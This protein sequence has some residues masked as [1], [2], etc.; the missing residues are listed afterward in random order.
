[1]FCFVFFSGF[2][3]CSFPFPIPRSSP[4]PTTFQE[5]VEDTPAL[6]FQYQD[7]EA[8]TCSRSLV[9]TTAYLQS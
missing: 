6:F 9:D 1:M 8:L 7:G 2:F 4:F 3:F 5:E